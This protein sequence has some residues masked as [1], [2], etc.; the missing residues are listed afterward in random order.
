MVHRRGAGRLALA[1]E[2]TRV[3]GRSDAVPDDVWADATRH[4]DERSLSALLLAIS[5]INVWNR[6]NAATRQVAGS[7]KA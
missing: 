5:T 4:Y 1:E 2:V 7:I 3:A 6:L